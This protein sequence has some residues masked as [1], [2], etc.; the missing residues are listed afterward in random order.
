MGMTNEFSLLMLWG[1][2][3]G[4]DMA[5][6]GQVMISRPLVAGTVAGMILGDPISGG[7]VGMV[8]ELFALDVLPVGSAR[9]PDYG[10]GAVAAATAAAGA[11]GVFGLGVAIVVGLVVAY[12]GEIGV[13]MIRRANSRD[14]R[15]HRDDLDAGRLRTVRGIH[16]R[17]LLRDVV[18]SSVVTLF[19]LGLAVAA[20]RWT[21]GTRLGALLMTLVLIGTSLGAATSGIFR[22]VGK[23]NIV[24]WFGLGIILGILFVVI[25]Q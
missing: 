4:V 15:R 25:V 16:Y 5:S 8:L 9:Y 1:T 21:P 7:T 20:Y 19:G 12:V 11:P 10:L 13:V 24:R 3:V 23:T 17:G 2:V 14:V 22:M 6:V 18:R